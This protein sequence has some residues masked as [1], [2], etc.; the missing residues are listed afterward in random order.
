M[1][2]R[3]RTLFVGE[4]TIA[5][6]G[7]FGCHEIKGFEKSTPIGAE[8][9]E[10]GSKLVDRLDFG[11]EHGKIPHTLPG[12]LKRKVEEP[13]IFDQ[14][15]VKRPEEML[16]MPKF[17]VSGEEADTIVTGIMSFTKEQVPLAAQHQL[18]AD[19]RQ[20]QAGQRL[21]RDY[22]CRGCHQVG[23]YGG[24]IRKVV[25]SQLEASGGDPINAL[26]LSPPL[27]YNSNSKIGEG[28]RV[29]TDWLHDFLARSFA[30]G[31]ALVRAAHAD[32]RVQRGAAQHAHPLLRGA[33]PRALP[34]QRPHK[35]I[36]PAMVAHGRDLFDKWQCIKCHVV[37]GKLP[38]Q[39]PA[40]MAPDL[41]NVP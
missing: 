17:W 11:Y 18:G 37:A 1:D 16:R 35:T 23:D 38:N 33:G 14:G 20:V 22:N 6:Y 13:R 4:K 8:L 28:A 2:D 10:Q 5:R 36:D 30:Q 34:D 12:W 15:K 39:E 29:H 24:A 40:N 21:V 7:C 3:Q 9:T 32:L 41:A 27:L 25:E 26:G 31:P 19:D